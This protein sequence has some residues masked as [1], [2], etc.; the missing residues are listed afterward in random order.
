MLK[1]SF[2]LS[3]SSPVSFFLDLAGVL[4]SAVFFTAGAGFGV[5]SDFLDFAAFAMGIMRFDG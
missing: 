3:S 5:V 2:P 1:A 4:A